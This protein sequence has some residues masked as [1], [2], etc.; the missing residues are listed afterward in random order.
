MKVRCLS[1]AIV[2]TVLCLFNYLRRKFVIWINVI[3]QHVK[4]DMEHHTKT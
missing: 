1:D 4:L 2:K 3:F